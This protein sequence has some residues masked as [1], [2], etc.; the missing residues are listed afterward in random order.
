MSNGT[1]MWDTQCLVRS[2]CSK[3]GSGQSILRSSLSNLRILIV[4]LRCFPR[5]VHFLQTVCSYNGKP[6]R[7][8]FLFKR[9]TILTRYCLGN[10][11]PRF[12]I[13]LNLTLLTTRVLRE[14]ELRPADRLSFLKARDCL[15]QRTFLHLYG[16][17]GCC[18][19]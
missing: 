2:H 3:V 13:G 1:C 8:H 6:K 12:L 19:K 14:N 9:C 18:Q 17:P 11:F 16:A 15:F 5:P 4:E 7:M 10:N